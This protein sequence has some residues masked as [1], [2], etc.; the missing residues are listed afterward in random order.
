MGFVCEVVQFFIDFQ[1]ING[2]M[3]G[4]IICSQGRCYYISMLIYYLLDIY[5]IIDVKY[6]LELKYKKSSNI[7]GKYWCIHIQ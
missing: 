3:P 1:Y 4:V 5:D 6:K 7:W 2:T